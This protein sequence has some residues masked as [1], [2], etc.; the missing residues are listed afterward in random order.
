MSNNKNHNRNRNNGKGSGGNRMTVQDHQTRMQV[1][2]ELPDPNAEFEPIRIVS[3]TE[4]ERAQDDRVV[5]FYLGDKEYTIPAKPRT[6]V[7]IK[8]LR[9]IRSEGDEIAQ[10]NMLVGLLGEEGFD[11]LC[12]AEDILP[13]QF[14]AIVSIAAAKTLGALENTTKN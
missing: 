10:A 14:E 7:A 2:S 6:N 4:E 12:D 9:D 1:M 5:L 13:E 3:R 11:A 8:Y